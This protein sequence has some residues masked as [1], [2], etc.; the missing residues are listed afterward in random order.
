MGV[1]VRMFIQPVMIVF[2]TI[3][4]KRTLSSPTRPNLQRLRTTA[5]H[6]FPC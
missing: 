2:Y 5:C 6:T 1:T 4:M 3:I